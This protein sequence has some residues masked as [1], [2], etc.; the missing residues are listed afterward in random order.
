MKQES[1]NA[2]VKTGILRVKQLDKEKIKSLIK[3]AE[4][5]AEVAKDVKLN[6]NSATLIFREIYESVRQLGDAYWWSLGYE[7]QNHEVSM[8]ILKEM[9]IKNK[10]KLNHLSRFKQIRHDANY[11]GFMITTQQAEEILD[12]WNGCGKDIIN[13]IKERIKT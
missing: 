7:S 8:D 2:M 5:N 12:F 11:R 1:I 9:D 4:T 10:I 3:S 6:E 13:K